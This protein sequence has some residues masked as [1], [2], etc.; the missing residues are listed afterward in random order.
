MS[1]LDHFKPWKLVA[2]M[3]F[4]VNWQGGILRKGQTWK[5]DYVV[6]FYEKSDSIRKIKFIGDDDYRVRDK[7]EQLVYKW[8]E[9]K[10]ELPIEARPIN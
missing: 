7:V 4:S 1:L 5:E 9:N 3:E 6:A 8:R 10:G 2:E